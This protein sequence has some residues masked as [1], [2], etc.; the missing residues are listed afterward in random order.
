MLLRDLSGIFTGEG[1]VRRDGRRV[2]DADCGFV[3][4]PVDLSIDDET[5]N[6]VA[7]G[8]RLPGDGSALDGPTIDGRGRVALPGFIDPHTHAIF[9]GERSGEYFMRWA[10]RTY[11]EIAQAGGGIHSTVAATA[12]ATD[13]ELIDSLL[14][15]L[16]RML[17]CGATTVEVKSGYANSAR[18]ELRLL[19]CVSR[20]RGGRGVPQVS[21]TF[22]GL[23]ALPKG[24]DEAGYVEEMIAA[25]PEVAGEGLADHVDSFPEKGFFSLD[26]ALRFGEAARAH[27]IACKVHA[28]ELCDLGSSAAFARA[29]ARSVDHLQFISDEAVALLARSPTVATMLP[30]TSFFVGI[31]FA[32]ARRLLD[33]GARV[34]LASDFNPGTA[35]ACDLQLTHLLAAGQMRMSA[36]EVLCATT[37]N[38]AAALGLEGS[39]GALVPRRR[40]DVL[41]YD[42]PAAGTDG[43]ATLRRI[44]LS[45][46]TP[47]AVLLGGQAVVEAAR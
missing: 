41:L 7:V 42:A 22:L 11:L 30:A 13:D 3:P 32:G 40:G 35:P 9:A 8:R 16:R 39:R 2:G 37:Y 31:P 10:G 17:A 25:L 44:L 12:E 29:G 1:F 46:A 28:D 38:A 15:R 20:A 6:V 47:E 45:R 24:R 33:A 21:A 23:H 34:A 14:D 36:A 5:G 19:R 4:G 27:G 43:I 26:A 18:G